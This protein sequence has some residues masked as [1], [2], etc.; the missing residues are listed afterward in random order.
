MNILESGTVTSPAGFRAAAVAAH[1]KYADRLDLALIISDSDCG[2]AGVFTQNQ[3]AAAPVLVDKEM[4]ELDNGRIRAIIANAGN[5]NA[6]TGQPGLK[7]ARATQQIAAA[8]LDCTPEQVLI[9]STGVIGVQL[10][11]DKM[12]AG[13][14]S[15]ASQLTPDGGTAVAQAIMTTDTHPKHTAVQ[16]ELPGGPESGGGNG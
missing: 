4:L 2:A 10:P 7:N 3:V 9:L 1:I 13:I 5:A 16:V 8:S 11:M 14:E 15:A 6:S 12:Q